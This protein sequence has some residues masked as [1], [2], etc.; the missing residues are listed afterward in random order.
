MWDYIVDCIFILDVVVN[1]RTGFLMGDGE[2]ELDSKKVAKRYIKGQF[3]IDFFASLPIDWFL[4]GGQASALGAVKLPRL[5]RLFRLIKKF[6]KF[7]SARMLRVL[8]FVTLF[9]LFSHWVGCLWWTIGWTSGITG[10]QFQP[11]VV[12]QVARPPV[13]SPTSPPSSA[14][15]RPSACATLATAARAGYSG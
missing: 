5:L 10:W 11:D 2:I 6:D 7:A 12:A 3:I 14:A 4:V 13:P 8:I 15:A 1:F 9:L